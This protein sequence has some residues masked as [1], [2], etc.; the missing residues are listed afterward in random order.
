M[1]GATDLSAILG[2]RSVRSVPFA[3]TDSRCLSAN[4]YEKNCVALIHCLTAAGGCQPVSLEER[5]SGRSYLWFIAAGLV[6]YCVLLAALTGDIGFDGDDWW[7]LAIPYWNSFP[8]SLVLYTQKFLRP[9]E[10]LYWISLFELFGF[11]KVAF[12]LCSLLLL[13]GSAALMGVSLHR[14]FPGRR[15]FISI[16]AL[17]AFFLPPVSCL[18]YVLFTD[19]SRLSMLL[20]WASV[21]AFQ[22][23]ARKAAPWQGLLLP[24]ALYVSSFLTY[25]ASGFL[26][27]MAPLL[28]WPVHRKY[29]DRISDRAF[30]I[31]LS[32][33]ILAAFG[34]AVAIRLLF[35]N[36]GAV[37]Q[38]YF[39]PPFELLW[40]YFTLLPFYLV[41]PF[42][43]MSA[44]RWGLLAGLLTLL[45]AAG[46]LLFS[47]RH[48]LAV[49]V[50]AGGR[51]EPGSKWYLIVLGG[52]ILVLGM[53]PYQLAG[54][55]IFSPRL[56]DTLTVK[57]GL[58]PDG[59]LSWFNFTWASRI[60]SSASFG[61]AIL[62][63]AV[64]SGWRKSSA[65]LLG[66]VAVPVAIGFMAVFHTGLSQDWKEAAEIRND[67][68]RSLVSQVP[69]VTPG[70]NFVFLDL[71]CSH[72]RAEVI[73]QETNGLRE[74]I[75]M[76]YADR[77]LRSWRLYP[78]AYEE[79]TRVFQQAVV[80][81]AGFLSGA[82]QR[83]QEPAAHD[84]LLLFKRSGRE[85]ILLDTIRAQDGCVPTGIAWQGVEHLTSNF[86]RIEAW[87][88]ATSPQVRLTRDAWTSGLISTLELTKLKSALVYFRGSRYDVVHNSRVR[89]SFKRHLYQVKARL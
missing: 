14:A 62:L 7:V 70:T 76:L 23:W 3:T 80:T 18:T 58:V 63:A 8:H 83:Q 64:M 20:F 11:N 89:R 9:L 37:G 88:T 45:G 44:D 19:N 79:Y 56:I 50:A 57:F 60:Y 16:A 71:A 4:W 66:K 30:L 61:V 26:I 24:V 34:A 25:E 12:H 43:S 51:F 54:Y 2:A 6:L 22:R 86:W 82:G 68:V 13:A 78:Q 21:L 48:R 53:L 73:R 84:S 17:L 39:L 81:P 15:V 87:R 35:L 5:E 85:L 29:S 38:S 46:L 72:K 10:G 75:W 69:A 47:G 33:G 42:T 52:G 36:G 65:R 27:F 28:V 74:L 55:G 59:D 32:V 31:R 67:L 1:L 41:A 77:T 40:S 49:E